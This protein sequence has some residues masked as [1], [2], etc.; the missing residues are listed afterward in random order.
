MSTSEPSKSAETALS[1]DL[2]N[3][4]RYYLGG[5][6][7]LIVLTVLVAVA[8]A[9]LN[10]RWLVAAGL[11]PL[12]LGVLPCLAMCGLGLCMNK[13]AGQ[14]C[15]KKT[16]SAE[17]ATPIPASGEAEPASLRTHVFSTPEK[18]IAAGKEL[19]TSSDHRQTLKERN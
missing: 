5:R 2:L 4:T 13:M 14:S 15:S 3:A 11:A 7:G 17:A 10:W 6:R 12:L 18:Q 8:G 9:A 16:N 1:Q 19:A